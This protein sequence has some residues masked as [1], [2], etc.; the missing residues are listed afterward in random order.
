[1]GRWEAERIVRHI[2]MGNFRIPCQDRPVN[3]IAYDEKLKEAQYLAR[4][5]SGG[6]G[7]RAHRVHSSVA[8]GRARAQKLGGDVCSGTIL[9]MSGHN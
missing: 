4:T 3:G 2:E 5:R 7:V 1:M 9:H 6:T 8:A